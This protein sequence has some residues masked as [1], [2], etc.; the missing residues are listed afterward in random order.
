MLKQYL[1][2]LM[3]VIFMNMRQHDVAEGALDLKDSWAPVPFIPL[4]NHIILHK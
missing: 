3:F 1:L 2:R 4:P